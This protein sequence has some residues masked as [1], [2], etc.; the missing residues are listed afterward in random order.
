MGLAG[1]EGR[2]Y[3]GSCWRIDRLDYGWSSREPRNAA[4]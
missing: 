1:T 3:Q 2:D 4:E